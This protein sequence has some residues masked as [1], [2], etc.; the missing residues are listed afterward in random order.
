MAG[1]VSTGL[2]G[3]SQSV[4]TPF[5]EWLRL[6][7]STGSKLGLVVEP[8]QVR[9]MP[10]T[11]DGYMWNTLLPENKSLFAKLLSKHST[12]VYIELCRGVNK[13]FEAVRPGTISSGRE[14]GEHTYSHFD[15]AVFAGNTHFVRLTLHFATGQKPWTG[16]RPGR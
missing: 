7:N 10:E 14:W 2:I 6:I 13:W 5:V 15:F 4:N 8:A 9:L 11:G 1:Q 16:R 12:G 3:S